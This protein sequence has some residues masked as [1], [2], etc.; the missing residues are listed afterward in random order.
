MELQIEKEIALLNAWL[1]SVFLIHFVNPDMN[2]S[3]QF[4]F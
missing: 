2:L 4:A 3:F 1:K